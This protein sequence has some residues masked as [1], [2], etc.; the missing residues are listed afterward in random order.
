[1]DLILLEERSAFLRDQKKSERGLHCD[2]LYMEF[3]NMIDIRI[4]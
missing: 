3:E 4:G 2:E 1:M